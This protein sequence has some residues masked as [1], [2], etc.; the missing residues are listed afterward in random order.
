MAEIFPLPAVTDPKFVF[1]THVLGFARIM[2]TLCP[3][4]CRQTARIGGQLPP[5]LPPV[6]YAYASQEVPVLSGVPQ[7]TVL[8]PLMFLTY[9]NYIN[10]N[11]SGTIKLFADDALLFRQIRSDADCLSLQKCR[12]KQNR[13]NC[14][15]TVTA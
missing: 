10:R 2:S 7:G 8:G 13:L 11:I 14:T 15:T 4:S 5:P 12:C 1:F 3:N 9:I 6:P